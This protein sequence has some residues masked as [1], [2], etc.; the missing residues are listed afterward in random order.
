MVYCIIWDGERFDFGTGDFL[1]VPC[2]FD[3][4]MHATGQEA[5]RMLVTLSPTRSEKK[6]SLTFHWK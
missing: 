5:L 3:H 2:G 6:K 4:E 1:F